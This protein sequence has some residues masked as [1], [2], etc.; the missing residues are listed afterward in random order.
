MPTPTHGTPLA[1]SPSHPSETASRWMNQSSCPPALSTP[2]VAPSISGDDQAGHDVR[3]Q[4]PPPR[5]GVTDE[6]KHEHEHQHVHQ[7]SPT[8]DAHRV[9]C[10]EESPSVATLSPMSSTLEAKE[11]EAL[12]TLPESQRSAMSISQSHEEEQMHTDV[13]YIRVSELGRVLLERSHWR[14]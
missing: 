11:S 12:P 3:P 8:S 13:S 10:S 5:S 1:S 4:T 14:C 9:D 7:Q 2:G 6:P